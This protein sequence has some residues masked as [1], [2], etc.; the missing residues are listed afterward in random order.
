M[1]INIYV[2]EH[3]NHFEAQL[4]TRFARQ[5]SRLKGATRCS[6]SNLLAQQVQVLKQGVPSSNQ[7]IMMVMTV[8]TTIMLVFLHN[9]H[10][11]SAGQVSSKRLHVAL[12]YLR[13]LQFSDRA[14]PS[15]PTCIPHSYAEPLGPPLSPVDSSHSPPTLQDTHSSLPPCVH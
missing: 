7:T 11:R 12:L 6:T 5:L 2:Y 8:L 3:G 14:T 15:R 4:R 1:C 9:I 13:R 10:L